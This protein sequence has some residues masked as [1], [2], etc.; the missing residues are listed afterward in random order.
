MV[1]RRFKIGE[2]HDVAEGVRQKRGE[3]VAGAEEYVRGEN[4]EYGRVERLEHRL[5]GNLPHGVE[6]ISVLFIRVVDVCCVVERKIGKV[7][8]MV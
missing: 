1:D 8:K 5:N 4:A 3:Q 7:V 6:A 2:S